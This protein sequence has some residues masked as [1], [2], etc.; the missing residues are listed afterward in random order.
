MVQASVK[1][2]ATNAKVRTPTSLCA[3]SRSMPIIMPIASDTTIRSM[4]TR[5]AVFD[6]VRFIGGPRRR[7]L[8]AGRPRARRDLRAPAYR[9][10][11][12]GGG[13]Q[14]GD[15]GR[16]VRQPDAEVVDPSAPGGAQDAAQ[17][18]ERVHDPDRQA[19]AARGALG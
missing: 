1:A 2:S 4:R 10:D 15:G 5:K 8:L 19:L 16:H 13:E 11:R 12:R 9:G 17:A 6:G 7:S 14:Q 18:V 3:H